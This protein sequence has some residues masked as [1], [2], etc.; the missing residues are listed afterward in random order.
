M[1]LQIGVERCVVDDE[2]M[3][4]VEECHD[5]EYCEGILTRYET[6]SCSYDAERETRQQEHYRLL[7]FTW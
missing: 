4:S 5:C 2:K 3:V 1:N 7:S 6:V